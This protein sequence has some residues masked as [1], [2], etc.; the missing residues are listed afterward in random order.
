M[1]E[2]K[3]GFSEEVIEEFC[4]GKIQD[5]NNLLP[6]L[7]RL[8]PEWSTNQLAVNLMEFGRGQISGIGDPDDKDVNFFKRYLAALEKENCKEDKFFL[9]AYLGGCIMGLVQL[10]HLEPESFIDAM[11]VS[12]KRAMSYNQ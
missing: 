2:E 7:K 5:F 1:A 4:S 10:G 6:N 12:R 8:H 3:K 11:E 9:A